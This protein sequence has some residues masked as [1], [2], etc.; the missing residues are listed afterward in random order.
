[1]D[2]TPDQLSVFERWM[3]I[4]VDYLDTQFCNFPITNLAVIDLHFAAFLTFWALFFDQRVRLPVTI[5]ETAHTPARTFRV[6]INHLV[7]LWLVAFHIT[8][9]LKCSVEPVSAECTRTRAREEP[10]RVEF[11]TPSDDDSGS[12]SDESESTSPEGRKRSA[13]RSFIMSDAQATVTD[14]LD[15]T[16][17]L[18]SDLVRSLTLIRKLDETY[19]TSSSAVHEL[20]KTYGSLPRL[21]PSESPD[22]QQLR[23]QISKNLSRSIGARE[24]SYA[25]AS[26]LYDVVDRHYNRLTS[27]ISKL[28]SLPQ[29]PSRDPSPTPLPSTS[30]QARRPR[31]SGHKR[32]SDEAPAPRITLR[33]DG[34]ARSAASGRARFAGDGQKGRVR[35]FIVPG[36]VL[37]PPN[38][39]SPPAHS[40]SDWES[41]PPSP[42]PVPTSRVGSSRGVAQPTRIRLLNAPKPPKSPK[43]HKAHKRDKSGDPR[44][45]KV[46]RGRRPPGVMGTNVH[47]AVAGISTSNA[48]ALLKPPPEDAIPGSEDAPWLKLTPYE[49]A[50]LRK[51][52]KKN[53]VW[54]PSE[55]MV[56]RE[57]ADLGR[58]PERYRAARAKAAATGEEVVDAAGIATKPPGVRQ[59]LAEGEISAESL[60]MDDL[61]L[62]NRGMKLNEAKKLKKEN[63]QKEL[64]AQAAADAEMAAQRLADSG[65]ALKILFARPGAG[66]AADAA[67]PTRKPTSGP[68]GRKRKR[69]KTSS[70]DVARIMEEAELSSFDPR[71]GKKRKGNRRPRAA[72]SSTAAAT[73]KTTVTVP[74]R[75]SKTPTPSA[76]VA[77]SQR[78]K[79][80]NALNT[81]QRGSPTEHARP[82]SRP[83]SR[84]AT[85]TTTQRA[86]SP[87]PPPEPYKSSAKD[88]PRRSGALSRPTTPAEPTRTMA[89]RRG[90]RPVPGRLTAE[91]S[92]GGGTAVIVGRRAAAPRNKKSATSATSARAAGVAKKTSA[93]QRAADE[94]RALAQKEDDDVDNDDD[95]VEDMPIDP[96]EPRYCI[97]GDVSYG[98]MC[99]REWF[100]LDCVGLKEPPGRTTKWYCPDCKKALGMGVKSQGSTGRRRK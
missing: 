64:A 83:Q 48:L 56:R 97:C 89:A 77:A 70:S 9:E 19:I 94:K 95:E 4:N 79:K 80:R 26:R 5:P 88:R 67:T 44:L 54:I 76:N 99:E 38:A 10:H 42:L 23:S 35:R 3:W 25:E 51:R 71:G 46:P 78:D 21:P 13:L 24:S 45:P 74:I 53:A 73:T 34:A 52:M 93:R 91:S 11:Q 50:K 17:Y 57:L 29:P 7:I 15:Y 22:P 84:G 18:P 86:P 60:G 8:L 37:P 58:G 66:A 82:P 65:S 33:L 100:H 75:T 27:I 20:T 2:K 61:Q 6:R 39:E 1:M 36:E 87:T 41:E 69:G 49:M 31:S 68:A 43:P 12:S 30:P 28:Q 63:L 98:T 81:R 96:D 90:K 14:F 62:S 85:V 59:I 16:E 92:Q 55:T 40:E 47:S 72:T 32:A